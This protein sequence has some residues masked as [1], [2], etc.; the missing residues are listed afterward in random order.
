LKPFDLYRVLLVQDEP[1]SFR[2]ILFLIASCSSNRF[3][4][5]SF[6]AY[7]RLGLG[8][9]LVDGLM[10]GMTAAGLLIY[11]SI[12]SDCFVPTK[13]ASSMMAVILQWQ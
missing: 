9:M 10:V 4:H 12:W 3:Y 8:S 11:T 13:L 5:K 1:F 7:L 2:C 6:M